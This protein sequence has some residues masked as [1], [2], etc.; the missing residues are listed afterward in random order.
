MTFVSRRKVNEEV[1]KR[2][3]EIFLETFG[4]LKKKEDITFFLE[5]FLTPTERIVLS[6]RLAIAVM[7]I[8]GYDYRS[9]EEVLKVTSNTIAKVAYWIKH[10][11]KGFSKIID[12]VMAKEEGQKFWQDVGIIVEKAFTLQKRINMVP[13]GGM[14]EPPREEK[15][16]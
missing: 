3:L 1:S 7:L 14:P 10:R 5:E 13:Y 6:K 15:P 12:D 16:F 4:A 8:K 2:L 9:I 11:K